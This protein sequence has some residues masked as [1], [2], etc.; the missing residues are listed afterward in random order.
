MPI[1]PGSRVGKYEVRTLLGQGG[2]GMVFMGHDTA[3][4]RDCALKFLLPEH[5]SRPEILQRFL[6]EARSAA[7]IKHGG[8]VTVF[9]CG[10]VEGAGPPLDGMAYIAMELLEGESLSDRVKRG[11]MPVEHA[12]EITR[13]VASA[14]AAAHAVGIIH[15]DL[16]PDNIYLVP[17]PATTF[18]ERVKVLDFGIAKLADDTGGNAAKTSTHMIFGTPKYMSPEQCKS[19]AK[20]DERSDIYALGCILFEM[21]CG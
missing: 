10:T 11:P 1:A 20:V 17:D 5:T 6:K 12:L 19:T 4:D 14:L 7:K 18:G 13:Q 15:R 9:E 21:V 3:L 2:F 8:I 16:K